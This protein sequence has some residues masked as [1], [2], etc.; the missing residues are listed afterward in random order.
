MTK[1]IIYLIRHGKSQGNIDKVFGGDPQLT[2][3]GINQVKK[4][5]QK[6]KACKPS[7]VYTSDRK[8]TRQTAQIL[9]DR[10]GL[11]VT[12]KKG[13][14]ERSYGSLEGK[15]ILAKHKEFHNKLCQ[16]DPELMWD[17]HLAKNDETNRQAFTR[18]FNQ[19]KKIAEKNKGKNSLVI[20][21]GNVIRCLLVY[22]KTASFAQLRSESFANAGFIKLSFENSDFTILKK[23]GLNFK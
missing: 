8:R 7:A 4:L 11:K 13:L 23:T 17:C 6:L 9:A 3:E 2:T 14:R 1:T 5:A 19:L 15:K 21:H 20:A 22:L 18:F 12:V 16:K 10:W